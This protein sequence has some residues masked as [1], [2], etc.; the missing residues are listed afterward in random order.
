MIY[1]IIK[2]EGTNETP[3]KLVKDEMHISNN[4]YVL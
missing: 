2:Q 1:E 3:K 4:I